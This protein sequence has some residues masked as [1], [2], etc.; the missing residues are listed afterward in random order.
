MST[1]VL[2]DLHG[3]YKA[4][5]QCLERSHFDYL[6]DKLIF[7]GDIYDGW[8]ESSLCVE[9]FLKIKNLIHLLGNHDDWTLQWATIGSMPDN[10]LVQGGEKTISSYNNLFS[11]SHIDF[12]NES[13][14]YHLDDNRLF[15]HAGFLP[16]TPLDQQS[17]EILSWDR[18]FVESAV[19]YSQLNK[20]IRFTKYNE[21]YVGHTPTIRYGMSYPFRAGEIW[22]MDTGAGWNGFLTIMD[23][24]SKEY[25]CSDNV[26]QLYPNETGR[27]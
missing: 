2:G 13:V 3:A 23:I 17:K 22:L 10:W 4:L 9:E 12:L 25:W 6:N 1:F 26:A 21:I 5:L 19:S 20:N 27:F 14:L 8:S 18:T 15:V 24:D 7:L 11:Q 16:D